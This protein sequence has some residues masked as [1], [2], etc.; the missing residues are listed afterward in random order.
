MPHTGT[1]ACTHAHTHAR[2]HACTH[3]RK[4]TRI[5]TTSPPR[6]RSSALSPCRARPSTLASGRRCW[7]WPPFVRTGRRPTS[8]WLVRLMCTI[9]SCRSAATAEH[10]SAA[11][12]PGLGASRTQSAVLRCLT[13]LLSA[14]C[15]VIGLLTSRRQLGPAADCPLYPAR[16]SVWLLSSAAVL[17]CGSATAAPFGAPALQCGL[18]ASSHPSGAVVP[19]KA[20]RIV[21]MAGWWSG[22]APA[23]QPTVAA[24]PTHN[25]QL[26]DRMMEDNACAFVTLKL[27]SSWLAMRLDLL[28]LIILTGT[29]AWGCGWAADCWLGC[30][31]D[32]VGWLGY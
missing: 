28:G 25:P 23:A 20:Y 3:A 31:A 22:A 24:P 13:V 8:R 12:Q 27:A 16:S 32:G 9:P 6:A 14:L 2:T 11:R 18:L 5:G 29:G 1:H 7:G 30:P 4:Y 19:P 10:S 26:S 21:H 15:Q 17:R